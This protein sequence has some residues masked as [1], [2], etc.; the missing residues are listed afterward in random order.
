MQLPVLQTTGF[1]IAPSI[2]AYALHEHDVKEPIKHLFPGNKAWAIIDR[3]EILAASSHLNDEDAGLG[4]PPDSDL[5]AGHFWTLNPTRDT[6]THY[7][8]S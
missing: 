6:R 4:L 8:S 2:R 7:I 3:I 5:H 1:F